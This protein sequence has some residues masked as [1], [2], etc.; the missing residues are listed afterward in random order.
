MNIHPVFHVSLLEPYE[1]S[2]RTEEAPPPVLVDEEEEYEVDQVLDSRLHFRHL[3]YLVKWKGYSDAKNSWL[4]EGE[5]GNAAE[6]TEEFHRRYPAKPRPGGVKTK[7]KRGK[8]K[9][10]AGQGLRRS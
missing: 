8:K 2:N 9:S 7:G 5:L 1:G 3:Q 4:P 10:T 6:L